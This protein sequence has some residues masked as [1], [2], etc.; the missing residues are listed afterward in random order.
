M[1]MPVLFEFGA[2]PVRVITGEDGKYWFS[3]RLQVVDIRSLLLR[4][5][6]QQPKRQLA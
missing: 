1:T 2:L 6:T 3:T 4:F 5:N